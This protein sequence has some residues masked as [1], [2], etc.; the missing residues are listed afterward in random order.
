MG[1]PHRT[2]ISL[3]VVQGAVQVNDAC[4]REIA[5]NVQ[6]WAVDLKAKHAEVFGFGGDNEVMLGRGDRTLYFDTTDPDK[7]TVLYWRM[8]KGWQVLSGSVSRYTLRVIVANTRLCRSAAALRF[9]QPTVY[10]DHGALSR[11]FDDKEG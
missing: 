1:K 3:H 5:P 4:V 8:S 2:A 11:R 7:L 9:A 10:P 6:E